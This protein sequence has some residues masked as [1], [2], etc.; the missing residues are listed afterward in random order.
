MRRCWRQLVG[1]FLGGVEEIDGRGSVFGVGHEIA[2]LFHFVPNLAFH[3]YRVNPVDR[4]G[5]IF[6]SVNGNFFE[7]T[8]QI[9]RAGQ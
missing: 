9:L 2:V 4:A 7:I 6:V 5:I 8:F 3:R 1:G